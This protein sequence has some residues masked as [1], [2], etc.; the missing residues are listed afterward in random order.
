MGIESTII[1]LSGPGNARILRLGPIT[2]KELEETLDEH[3]EYQHQ[4]AKSADHALSSPGQL[5]KHYQPHTPVFLR[6]FNAPI[7]QELTE[8]CAIVHMRKPRHLIST[9]PNEHHVYLS[10]SGL[11]SE[12]ASHLYHCLRTLDK[13]QYKSILMELAPNEGLGQSINDRLLRAGKPR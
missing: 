9:K 5:S 4:T 10:E 12:V 1:D 3:V 2:Q 8:P 13:G 7:P 6:P 11:L